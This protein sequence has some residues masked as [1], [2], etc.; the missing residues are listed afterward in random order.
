M[1]KYKSGGKQG[2]ETQGF[3]HL[4]CPLHTPMSTPQP[5]PTW[6][7]IKDLF[8]TLQFCRAQSEKLLLKTIFLMQE[9]AVM[10]KTHAFHLQK[11]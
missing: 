3:T 10:K 4:V 6:K 1:A 5:H 2:W 8:T 11:L 9:V 7:H